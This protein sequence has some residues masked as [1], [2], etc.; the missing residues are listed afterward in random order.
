VRL[1]RLFPSDALVPLAVVMT[2]TA[3]WIGPKGKKTMMNMSL[4]HYYTGIRL[5]IGKL[6]EYLK[7]F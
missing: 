7:A 3:S 6:L 2:Q 4:Q 1:P 5:V